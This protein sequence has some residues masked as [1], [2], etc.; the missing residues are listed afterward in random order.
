MLDINILV[1]KKKKNFCDA[2]D[3]ADAD[4]DADTEISKWLY[5]G[6]FKQLS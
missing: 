6:P 4:A 5:L 2:D 3:D 1:F